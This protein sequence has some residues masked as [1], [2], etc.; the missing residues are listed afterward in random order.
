MLYKM[1]YEFLIQII[2]MIQK[3]L[4]E[5][6]A[7]RKRV[8]EFYMKNKTE[9]K[10]YTA[11]HFLAEE[12]AKSTIYDI[13]KRA[14]SESGYERVVGSGRTAIIM[15]KTKIKRLKER[16]DH[17]DDISQRQAASEFDCSQP[18][19]SKTLATKTNIRER[20]K[21]KIPLRTE[22][23]KEDA[24]IKCSRLFFIMLKLLCI[25]DDESYF[26][27]GHTNISGN[28]RFYTSDIKKTWSSVKHRP[29]AKFPKKLLVWFCFSERGISEPYFVPSGTAINQHTYWKDCIKARLLPFIKK[30]HSDG[31]YIFWPDLASSH[32]A[33][34]VIANLQ[35]AKVNFVEKAAN[36]ANLPEVRPIEDLWG[37]I[38]AQVYKNNWQAKNLVQL[39]TRIKKCFKKLQ[40]ELIQRLARSIPS[41]LDQIRK[42]GVPER[43]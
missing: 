15:T 35:T 28:G 41:R 24:R 43:N 27:C 36:P 38:K 39:R 14:E 16:F 10:K 34:T 30:Y 20:K 11:D 26:T 29:V 2:N 6:E 22:K 1:Q 21:I 3:N 33:K 5:Q 13:I 4:S 17:K 25:M 12:V 40:P 18:Y 37:I 8:Y 23:Q 31:K 19:I 7:L 9:G 32:Y 42:K